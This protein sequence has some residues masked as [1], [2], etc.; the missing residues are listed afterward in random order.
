MAGIPAWNEYKILFYLSDLPVCVRE[1]EREE[2]G[3]R[4][5][6]KDSFEKSECERNSPERQ[7]K[8]FFLLPITHVLACALHVVNPP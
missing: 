3:R 2:R 6:N 4:E 1:R 7:I 5:T 8:D